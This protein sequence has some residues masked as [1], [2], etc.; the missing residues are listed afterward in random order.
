MISVHIGVQVSFDAATGV[1]VSG[2]P[3]IGSHFSMAV[4]AKLNAMV[5]VELPSKTRFADVD[6]DKLD[7]NAADA[8]T[9][10]T[11]LAV[12]VKLGAIVACAL[13]CG[14]TPTVIVAAIAIVAVLCSMLSFLP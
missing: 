4:V 3:A 12:V 7:V 8:V 9:L 14:L 1:H 5:D 13:N 10:N 6:N 11:A 2:V